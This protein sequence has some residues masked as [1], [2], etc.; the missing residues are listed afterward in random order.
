MFKVIQVKI[1]EHTSCK[2][3]SSE[4]AWYDQARVPCGFNSCIIFYFYSFKHGPSPCDLL[5]KLKKCSLEGM[6]Q[7]LLNLLNDPSPC[8]LPSG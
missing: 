5:R 2:K 8:M 7:F 6:G 3:K 1:Q 4:T